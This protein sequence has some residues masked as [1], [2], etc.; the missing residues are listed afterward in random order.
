LNA[1]LS[2]LIGFK[3]SKLHNIYERLQFEEKYPRMVK[4]VNELRARDELKD[5]VYSMDFWHEYLDKFS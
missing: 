5:Q 1:P 3:G 4:L 2:R